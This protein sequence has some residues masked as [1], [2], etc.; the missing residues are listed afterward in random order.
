MEKSLPYQP[1]WWPL[2]VKLVGP[3]KFPKKGAGKLRLR[4][5]YRSICFIL[6]YCFNCK[7]NLTLFWEALYMVIWLN[8]ICSTA[9][10]MYN[11]CLYFFFWV[12]MHN[13]CKNI[14]LYIYDWNICLFFYNNV[15]IFFH[16]LIFYH[17]WYMYI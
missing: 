5:S 14:V 9:R 3:L 15:M 10:Y 6:Y 7:F 1:A 17:Q 2:Q 12:Q 16:I 11:I 8:H 4:R 13:I